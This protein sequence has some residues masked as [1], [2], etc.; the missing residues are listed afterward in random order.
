MADEH[1]K[2]LDREAAE[3]LLRGE[4]L[5]AVAE[6]DAPRAA[7]LAAA[8]DSLTATRVGPDGELPGEDAALKAFREARAVS[9]VDRAAAFADPV[10]LSG[11]SVRLGRHRAGARGDRRGPRWGRPVRFGLAAAVAACMVGGVAVAAGTGVLPSPF[12]RWTD[13]SPA[14]SVSSAPSDQ[15]LSTPSGSA[16][17]RGETVPGDAE[18]AGRASGSP[19]ADARGGTDKEHPGKDGG[20]SATARPGDR[21]TGTG[22]GSDALRRRIVETCTKYRAGELD[23]DERK[24]L[25]ESQKDS[26]DR[27]ANLARFC[28]RALDGAGD[29]GSSDGKGGSGGK[30]DGDEEGNEDGDS[31]AAPS[32]SP[33]IA[34]SPS[35]SLTFSSSVPEPAG[36][37]A[38]SASDDVTVSTSPTP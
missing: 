6:Q 37:P 38:P 36:V 14:T 19:D 33:S 20:A 31:D 15:P 28:E 11:G 8:L 22:L 23:P 17:G 27:D 34:P 9:A 35:E 13:P 1:D 10:T 3:R 7:R 4:P 5:E 12:G 24:W 26:A 29:N 18:S 25:R 30:G 21:A 32:G 2:W 16:T